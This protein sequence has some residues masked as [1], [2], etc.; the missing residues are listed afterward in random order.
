MGLNP[1][2]VTILNTIT[3]KSLNNFHLYFTEV[4]AKVMVTFYLTVRKTGPQLVNDYL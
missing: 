1:Q 4:K 2:L 3:D